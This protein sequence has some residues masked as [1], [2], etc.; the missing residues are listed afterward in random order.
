MGDQI[1]VMKNGQVIDERKKQELFS[2]DRHM[3]TKTL[4]DG[5]E[6]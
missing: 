4:L 5:F 1:M 6:M 2:N 3:Y